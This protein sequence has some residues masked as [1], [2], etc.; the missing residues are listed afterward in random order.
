M[1]FYDTCA[2]LNLRERAFEESFYISSVTLT[3]L[4]DI[5]TSAKKDEETKWKARQV[6]KLL[7]NNNCYK[8]YIP[9]KEEHDLITELGLEI[10]NDTLIIASA[11]AVYRSMNDIVFVTDDLLCYEFAKDVFGIPVS[12]SKLPDV[13]KY[14]GYLEVMDTDDRFP[15]VYENP[16]ANVFDALQ[17]QYIVVRNKD[18]EVVDRLKWNGEEYKPIAYK[19]IKNSFLGKIKPRNDLQMC[20]FDM[21]QNED[22]TI[23]VVTGGYGTGKDYCMI[24]NALNLVEQNKYDKIIWVRNNIEV[25]N[26][27]QIGYLPGDLKDKLLPFAM[28]MADHL[29]GQSG[30]EMLM[31]CGKIEIQHLG[32]IR[33]RDLKNSIVICSEAEN[34]TKE[35]IQLLIGRIGEGS[36]LWLNGDYRQTD[37][38]IFENNNGLIQAIERLKGHH[39]FGFIKLE[40]VERSETASMADLLD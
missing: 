28:V 10:T 21:L 31:G 14:T 7:S 30:L 2:L 20:V 16:S 26:S 4:E 35:H 29:G 33:G 9:H 34:M 12:K 40:Q 13:E 22:I 19:T 27:Q 15:F 25:K 38:A 18:G 17:N 24:S 37:K 3:E 5:K 23:K 36:T 11:C 6:V 39:R 32:F 1:K 8:I